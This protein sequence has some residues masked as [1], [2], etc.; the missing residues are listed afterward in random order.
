MPQCKHNNCPS[1]QKF[2][3]RGLCRAC[4]ND[5]AIRA[6]YPTLACGPVP[7]DPTMEEMEATIAEQLATMP[8]ER[9]RRK[10]GVTDMLKAMRKPRTR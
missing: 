4:H 8:K 7:D 10:S 2:L 9:Y 6:L 1:V 5:P 3:V